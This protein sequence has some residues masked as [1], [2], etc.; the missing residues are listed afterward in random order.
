[1]I[2]QISK[3]SDNQLLAAASFLITNSQRLRLNAETGRTSVL[4]AVLT[5]TVLAESDY[6]NLISEVSHAALS[7]TAVDR[8]LATND[9]IRLAKL[10]QVDA[11]LAQSNHVSG[12]DWGNPNTALI[13]EPAISEAEL[14]DQL[15]SLFGA[16]GEA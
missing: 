12:E 4:T 7:Q 3:Y 6:D 5:L 1:M 8:Q 2:S 10:S 15:V 14:L 9:Q 16:A 13:Q 11:L